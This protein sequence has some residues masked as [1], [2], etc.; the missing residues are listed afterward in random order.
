M[1]KK[2]FNELRVQVRWNELT[3][4]P[5]SLDRA[6]R[7]EGAFNSGGAQLQGGREDRTFEIAD[8]LDI[9]RGKHAIRAGVLFEGGR[10]ESD[11]VQNIGGT[12]T[13]PSLTAYDLGL[14]T[15]Y[16]QKIGDPAVAYSTFFGAWYVQDDYRASKT[17]TLSVGMRQEWQSH[18]DDAWNIA[19]RVGFSWAPFENGRTTFR[20]GAGIFYDWFDAETY[21]QTLQVNGTTLQ[22]VLVFD[23]GF[24][25][26]FQAAASKSCRRDG[27]K[28]TPA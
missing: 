5:L 27:S 2:A 7:V 23:P 28:P 19:P 20:G 12:F 16:R 24:P 22:D 1:G 21:E 4:T 11:V 9:N 25:D 26:R 18:V 6:V 13:F 15:T 14:A 10:Y 8:N 3:N 17:L